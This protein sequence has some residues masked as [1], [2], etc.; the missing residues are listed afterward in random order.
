MIACRVNTWK[1]LLI[2]RFFIIIS[3][4]FFSEKK[5]KNFRVKFKKKYFIST[6]HNRFW[7]LTFQNKFFC[8]L[9]GLIWT[10]ILLFLWITGY[11]YTNSFNDMISQIPTRDY[12][13]VLDC[14][15]SGTRW[16]YR[17]FRSYF[18]EWKIYRVFVYTWNRPPPDSDELLDISPLNDDFNQPVQLKVEPGLSS[19]GKF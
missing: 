11:G 5:F 15:S 9:I 4:Y 12:G 3:I 10:G 14:G 17:L 18:F 6:F 2:G 16:E 8:L 13:I 7:L 19:F 1:S